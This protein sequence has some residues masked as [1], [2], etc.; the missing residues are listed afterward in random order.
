MIWEVLG[1]LDLSAFTASAKAV[2]H[3]AGGA[4]KSRRLLLAL[5]CY[6]LTQRILSAREISRRLMPDSTDLAFR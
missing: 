3:G 4:V 2:E 6:A 5:W 1:I